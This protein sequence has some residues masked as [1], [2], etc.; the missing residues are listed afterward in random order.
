MR[1]VVMVTTLDTS[2]RAEIITDGSYVIL[3][4]LQV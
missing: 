3:T 4:T 1:L 2:T